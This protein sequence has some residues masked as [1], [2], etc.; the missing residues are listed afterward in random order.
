MVPAG[1]ALVGRT[2]E[3]DR[4]TTSLTPDSGQGRV[5]VV[6]GEAGIGKSA[7]VAQAAAAT[8]LTVLAGRGDELEQGWPFHLFRS[9]LDLLPEPAGE[10]REV[11]PPTDVV[12]SGRPP[13]LLDLLDLP[14]PQ[15]DL[16]S[17][18]PSAWSRAADTVLAVVE[19]RARQPVLMVAEDLHWADVQSLRLVHHVA[20]L[21]ADRPLSLVATT[22]PTDI[23]E[24]A[25]LIDRL[26]AD[27]A[28]L[29]RLQPLRGDA[30]AALVEAELGAAPGLRLRTMAQ[31]SGGNPLILSQLIAGLVADG[32]LDRHAGTV[33]LS[34]SA[35]TPATLRA[36]V[37]RRLS[38]LDP[39]CAELLRIAA[40]V[41]SRFSIAELGLLMGRSAVTMT[42]AIRQAVD[43]GLV[44]DAG[45][46]LAFQHDLVR[47]AVYHDL[48]SALRRELHRELAAARRAAGEPTIRVAEHLA[49]GLEQGDVHGIGEVRAAV[50]SIA[51]RAPRVALALLD[52]AASAAG[53]GRD[54]IDVDRIEPRAWLGDIDGAAEDAA[55][56]LDAGSVP[57]DRRASVRSTLAGLRVLQRRTDDALH[58]FQLALAECDDDRLRSRLGA[59]SAMAHMSAGDFPGAAREARWARDLAIDVGESGSHAMA[60]GLLGRVLTYDNDWT[61]GL[62]LVREASPTRRSPPS[63]V[64]VVAPSS[65][66]WFVSTESSKSVPGPSSPS[67]WPVGPTST[68]RVGA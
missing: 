31:R 12:G 57:A 63:V 18:H 21:S 45:S 14:G 30:I 13:D 62:D 43:S 38:A 16:S 53:D 33:E 36:A 65:R 28:E 67:S 23:A 66:T 51:Y 4:L 22:R 1:K 60:A 64:R 58:Q 11:E 8:G 59:Q 55:R 10:G 35:E 54:V 50:A 24:V 29:V 41:G 6:E 52:R 46:E 49:F 20:G 9:M 27:G 47:D 48:P 3:L 68:D 25:A 17:V 2:S 56:L 26:V 5:V 39:G 42:E 37:R 44:V 61:A 7:L 19:E 34:R 15:G 32:S 40:V